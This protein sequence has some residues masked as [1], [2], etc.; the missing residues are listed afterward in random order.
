MSEGDLSDL[1]A[2]VFDPEGP[3]VT[4]SAQVRAELAAIDTTGGPLLS[5]FVAQYATFWSGWD[6]RYSFM[7]RL[8]EGAR[9]G[10]LF[11]FLGWSNRYLF[12]LDTGTSGMGPLMSE[13]AEVVGEE[14]AVL[15]L[16][17][18][19]L[20][21]DVG[22]IESQRRQNEGRQALAELLM[23]LRELSVSDAEARR[24]AEQLA[25]AYTVVGAHE[26]DQLVA[27]V[28]YYVALAQGLEAAGN[29]R[30]AEYLDCIEHPDTQAMR[31]RGGFD[32]R[33]G[34]TCIP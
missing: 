18:L 9:R 16:E 15:G 4:M 6:C 11:G 25:A 1:P 7:P 31:G 19:V 20:T 23:S 27:E 21:T 10:N 32:A 22:S 28:G 5:R 17:E 24:L 26:Q 13:I 33:G 2:G 34:G 14:E 12:N 3:S 30:L 29:T 8:D